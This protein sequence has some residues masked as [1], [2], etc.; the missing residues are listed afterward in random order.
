ML[1]P[2][3]RGFLALIVAV[4][5]LVVQL[6][7]L[8]VNLGIVH[9]AARNPGSG[10]LLIRAVRQLGAWQLPILALIHAGLIFGLLHASWGGTVRNAAAISLISLPAALVSSYSLALLQG[11]HQ[12][13]SFNWLRLLPMLLY[14]AALGSAFV[15]GARSLVVAS[16]VLAA[17][18]I[19]SAVVA[20]VTAVRAARRHATR[21]APPPNSRRLVGFG[22]RGVFGSV[23]PLET[24]R[25]D[26]LLVGALLSPA[27][28]G[29]YV[30][31]VAFAN[32]PRFV[33]QSVGMIAYP[34]IA[35][36]RDQVSL[37]RRVLT[38]VS[39]TAVISAALVL[40]LELTLGFL[41]PALFGSRFGSA[42]PVARVLLIGAFFL[43]VRVVLS[44]SLRGAG[45]PGLGALG[46]LAGI[47]FLAASL[48][49]ALHRGLVA[50]AAAFSMAAAF[51]LL[52]LIALSVFVS[53]RTHARDSGTSPDRAFVGA[54]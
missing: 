41:V 13:R 36:R 53:G 25:L 31:G 42:V 49:L 5:S 9:F 52:V 10:V 27:A 1:G 39:A 11:L 3:N 18:S 30:V 17:T 7:S 43:S 4:P 8:G 50:V 19:F 46:E 48:P 45:A 2:E 47:L 21:D 24:L 26:Q 34:A 38:F 16:F 14:S 15:L 28:L 37:L 40:V 51:A 6:G 20:L 54:R 35:A 22:L 23:S 32:L 33:A 44:D 12:F 29:I